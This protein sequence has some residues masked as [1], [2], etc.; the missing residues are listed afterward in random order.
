MYN[1]KLINMLDGY[2]KKGGHTLNINMLNVDTLVD[3]MEPWKLPTINHSGIW[4]RR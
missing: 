2:S 3:A 4:L 1:E